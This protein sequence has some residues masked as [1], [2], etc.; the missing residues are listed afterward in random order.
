MFNILLTLPY[1][2]FHLKHT[3]LGKTLTTIEA[4]GVETPENK[5]IIQEIKLRWSRIV[6]G[7]RQNYSQLEDFERTNARLMKKKVHKG[8]MKRLKKETEP[9]EASRVNF[10]FVLNHQPGLSKREPGASDSGKIEEITKFLAR[11]RKSS[12]PGA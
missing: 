5:R 12:R 4:S 2:E 1:N 6:I 8:S 9:G 3:K 7:I 11:M 10:N